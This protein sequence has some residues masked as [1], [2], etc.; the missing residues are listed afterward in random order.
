MPT[1]SPTP[2]ELS[3][4]CKYTLK[5]GRE[6]SQKQASVLASQ[7]I[8][9]IAVLDRLKSRLVEE[10]GLMQEILNKGVD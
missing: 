8:E 1:A 4:S 2:R 10:L 9:E 7:L 5:D 3:L 6:I